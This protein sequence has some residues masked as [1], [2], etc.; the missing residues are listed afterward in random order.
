MTAETQV[1]QPLTPSANAAPDLFEPTPRTVGNVIERVFGESDLGGSGYEGEIELSPLVKQVLYKPIGNPSEQVGVL[2]AQAIDIIGRKLDTFADNLERQGITLAPFRHTSPVDEEDGEIFTSDIFTSRVQGGGVIDIRFNLIDGGYLY[3]LWDDQTA[4]RVNFRTRVE[5]IIRETVQELQGVATEPAPVQ[6]QPPVQVFGRIDYESDT[7][8]INMYEGRIEL[9]PIAKEVLC[10]PSVPPGTRGLLKDQAAALILQKLN[11]MRSTLSVGLAEFSHVALAEVEGDEVADDTFD[12][13]FSTGDL[14]MISFREYSV[15]ILWEDPTY[16]RTIK[17]KV[18]QILK[19]TVQEL[20]GGTAARALDFGAEA[21]DNQARLRGPNDR[22]LKFYETLAP[23]FSIE[24]VQAAPLPIN[25]TVFDQEMNEDAMLSDFMLP[26]GKLVFLYNGKQTGI[27]YLPLMKKVKEG[28][29]IFYECTRVFP[30]NP[31]GGQLGTFEFYD[32]YAQPYIELALTSRFYIPLTDFQKLL[33]VP[34]HPYWE[35][36][37]TGKTLSAAASRSSVVAGGPIMSQLHCQDGSD[38]KVYSLSAYMPTPD[39]EDEEED[40]CPI[41]QIV[42][43][44]R[45][46]ERTQVDISE[47]NTVLGAKTWYAN[48]KGLTLSTLKMI[49]M[50]KILKDEDLLTPGTVVMVMGGQGG[51]RTYRRHKRSKSTRK[52][53]KA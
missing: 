44:Q 5:T 2:N 35:I 17:D 28:D 50:G 40:A 1:A 48:E 11:A 26:G 33:S 53:S 22:E 18:E 10:K 20:Q 12:A 37:D 25:N 34:V 30:F 36:K 8:I 13:K 52:T 41:P 51:R 3:L 32:I 23:A 42:T 38:L 16:A 39:P 31:N 29:G 45:G 47:N 9:S 21:V 46:E 19:E 43:L 15:Y 14:A 4:S 7:G 6:S 27:S 24:A 49:F